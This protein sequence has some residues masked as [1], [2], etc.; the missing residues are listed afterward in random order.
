MPEEFKDVVRLEINEVET[1]GG[2][3]FEVNIINKSGEVSK[4]YVNK[5]VLTNVKI[6]NLESI[7]S[8]TGIDFDGLVGCKKGKDLYK[9]LSCRKEEEK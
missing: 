3:A 1:L 5:L 2:K 6:K 9:F 8:L 4:D 7:P